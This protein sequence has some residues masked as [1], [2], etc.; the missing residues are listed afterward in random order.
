MS[1]ERINVDSDL[2]AIEE[3]V[4]SLVPE[5]CR[6][7]R[8]LVMFRAGQAAVRSL[9]RSR[10][11]WI[12]TAA[13]LGLIALAEAFLLA[14]RT[15]PQ[16]VERVIVVR[17]PARP[18]VE[19]PAERAVAASPIAPPLTSPTG[20]LALGRTAYERLVEQVIRYGLDGL[21]APAPTAWTGPEPQR[22]ASRQMLEEELRRVLD[23]GDHS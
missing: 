7:N 22:A 17:E 8:D 10:R 23:P 12:A 19:A 20:S 11:P 18:S 13:S 1:Q 14:R 15:P 16:I 6:I 21:P 4:G 3:A 2:S 5:R 9:R